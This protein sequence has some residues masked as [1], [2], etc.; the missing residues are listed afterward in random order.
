MTCHEERFAMTVS[1][2]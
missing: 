2:S 1:V